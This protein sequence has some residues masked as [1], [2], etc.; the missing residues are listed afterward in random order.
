MSDAAKRNPIPAP[1]T[2]DHEDVSWALSTAEAT[3]SRGDH[4]DALKWL[5]RAAEAASEAE[6]DDRALALAKAAAELATELDGPK[7]RSAPPPAP[8]VAPPASPASGAVP[9]APSSTTSAISPVSTPPHA[10]PEAAPVS[11]TA[12]RPPPSVTATTP[13]RPP[14]APLPPTRSPSAAPPRPSSAPRASQLPA[15]RASQ[16]PPAM[17]PVTGGVRPQAPKVEPPRETSR[18]AARVSDDA[19]LP[20]DSDRTAPHA[21]RHPEGEDTVLMRRPA[22][23]DRPSEPETPE[24]KRAVHLQVP[25][26]AKMPNLL[27]TTTTDEM[28]MDAWP[29]QATGRGRGGGLSYDDDPKTRIGTPAYTDERVTAVPGERAQPSQAV[30]VV[31]WRAA[32]GVHVAPHGTTVSAISVDAMLVALDPSADLYAWLSGK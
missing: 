31:V 32:D 27:E 7:A 24:S 28:D 9:V 21:P 12:S 22:P 25:R 29:T 26:A 5:R 3:W 13:S 30:R 14:P 4:A 6:D 11:A 17:R 19:K 15:P 20:V 10:G 23:S 2:D 8:S 1:T 16:N 18:G